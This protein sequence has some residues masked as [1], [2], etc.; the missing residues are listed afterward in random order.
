MKDFPSI[1][2]RLHLELTTLCNL[3]CAFCLHQEKDNYSLDFDILNK[4]IIKKEYLEGL[5]NIDLIGNSG[6]AIFHPKILD[7]IKNF[8]TE[9]P[10]DCALQLATN[11][12]IHSE[13]WWKDLAEIFQKRGYA[14]FSLDGIGETHSIHRESNFNTVFNN[15]KTFVGAGGKAVWKFILFDH[16]EHQ[17]EEAK[18]VCSKIGCEFQLQESR[19]YNSKLKKPLKENSEQKSNESIGCS[20]CGGAIYVGA[21]GL[22]SPCC[23]LGTFRES[24]FI[25]NSFSS[26]QKIK[27]LTNKKKMSIYNDNIKNIYQNKYFSWIRE[28]YLSLRCCQE[29]CSLSTNSIRRIG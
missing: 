14:V 12:S 6:D 1:I 22:V 21:D 5:K 8:I 7:I 19:N 3:R 29:S 9:M 20:F 23:S 17:V 11:G 16:N 10:K 13:N 26:K 25:F 24:P 18:N 4:S 15:M 27:F 28:N 2:T